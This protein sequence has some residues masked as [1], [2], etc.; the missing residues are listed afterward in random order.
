MSLSI[1]RS[2]GM[3][4]K[5]LVVLVPCLAAAIL[6]AVPAAAAGADDAGITTGPGLY[7]IGPGQQTGSYDTARGFFTGTGGV[8]VCSLVDLPPLQGVTYK[9]RLVQWGIGT[10]SPA[11]DAVDPDLWGF[12]IRGVNDGLP[13]ALIGDLRYTS[14][15]TPSA[16]PNPTWATQELDDA[17][18]T[19]DTDQDFYVCGG[20]WTAGIHFGLRLKADSE[21][22]T[23]QDDG[24]TWQ[25]E[26]GYSWDWNLTA[27][28]DLAPSVSGSYYSTAVADIGGVN[29]QFE[30]RYDLKYVSPSFGGFTLGATYTP[31]QDRGG[32][33]FEATPQSFDSGRQYRWS[34]GLDGFVGTGIFTVQGVGAQVIRSTR[35]TAA[36]SGGPLMIESVITST[37]TD[38]RVFGQW[39]PAFTDADAI[40]AGG[41]AHFHTTHDPTR[42]RVNFGVMALADGTTVSVTP[43]DPIDTPRASA[44]TVTL[45]R[46]ESFQINDV[47]GFFSLGSLANF[48]IELAVQS[49]SALA[50]GSVLDGT[51]LNPGTSDPTTVL[52]AAPSDRIT[53]LEVGPIQGINEFSGSAMIT[54]HSSTTAQVTAEFYA[55]GAPGIAAS[56]SFTVPS[57]DTLGLDDVVGDL[58][59]LANTVG[60]LVLRTTNGTQISAIGREFAVFRD[61]QGVVTGTA[62]QLMPGLTPDDLLTSGSTYEFLGITQRQDQTGIERAHLSVFRPGP[63][64][65]TVTLTLL[66]QDGSAEGTIQRTVRAGELLRLNNIADQVNSSQNGGLK[67]LMLT[68]TGN[69]HALVFTVNTT[70]DPVTRPAFVR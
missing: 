56:A 21:V 24:Q 66:N 5:G 61:T 13:G 11:G 67:S 17:S 40:A 59:G 49:G 47:H 46:G 12:R 15:L 30:S 53:L 39:F 28:V 2:R 3:P 57:G 26:V 50:V 51:A 65:A 37:L 23:S 62:G 68:T 36:S 54:N 58:L 25:K 48:M 55:R 18:G 42:Y 16:F 6:G 43:V 60:T 9:V 4:R 7:T 45:N 1:H 8:E 64:D 34:P 31:R 10:T 33:P 20:S 52:A 70:G 27:Q 29:S 32:A 22:V 69:V 44:H 41:R 63:G 35:A 19:L 14:S 38:G